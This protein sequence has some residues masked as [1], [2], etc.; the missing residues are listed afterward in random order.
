MKKLFLVSIM[1]LGELAAES[2]SVVPYVANIKYIDSSK[3]NGDLVGTYLGYGDLSYFTEFD[4]AH[5][6]IKYIDPTLKDLKQDDFLLTYASYNM[7]TMTKF[8]VHYI[9]TTDTNLGDGMIYMGAVENYFWE[10][11]DKVKIGLEG[12]LSDYKVGGSIKQLTPYASYQKAIS[13][14]TSNNFGL[15][16]N[17]ISSSKNYTSYEVEDTINYR[18]LATTF[19]YFTGKMK[20]GVKDSGSTVYNTEDIL[21]NGYSF[22][23]SYKLFY[24]L[25]MSGS[26][27]KNFFKEDGSS[28]QSSNSVLSGSIVYSF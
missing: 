20:T 4:Y 9:N 27:G 25:S 24:N 17:Y 13:Y 19:R 3:K 1:A 11:Y 16:V 23:M 2:L 18:N 7:E 6:N 14:D 21:Q 22:K 8:G 28:V 12:Y 26:Y 10:Y 15:K 5:T